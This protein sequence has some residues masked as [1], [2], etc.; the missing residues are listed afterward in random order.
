MTTPMPAST[1]LGALCAA[2]S[3]PAGVPVRDYAAVV[4]AIGALAETLPSV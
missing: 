2:R 3:S 4:R 1:A